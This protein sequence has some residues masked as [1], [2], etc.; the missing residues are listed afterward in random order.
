MLGVLRA[1]GFVLDVRSEP[2]LL[3]IEL[4]AQL[5]ATARERFEERDRTAAVAAVR[6]VLEPASIAVIGASRRRVSV[7]GTVVRNLV[8]AGFVGPVYPINPHAQTIA[9]RPAYGSLAEV[10][11][12]VELVVIAVAAGAV[13]AAARECAAAGVPALVVLSAGFGEAG[14]EGRA[15]QA[16]LL[17]ICR[18]AGMRLVGPNCLG[19][20]NTASAVRSWTSTHPAGRS[21]A[22][23][24]SS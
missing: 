18:E 6:H 12:P 21:S 17:E 10:P 22:L 16:E 4:P 24:S 15:R 5:S 19:V 11:A 7:G 23:R 8:A 20:L 14:E 13:L 9:G 1:S 2:G 3:E